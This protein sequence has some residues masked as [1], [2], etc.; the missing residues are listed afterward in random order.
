[1]FALWNKIFFQK[2]HSFY[3]RTI[4][5]VNLEKPTAFRV[6]VIR[7]RCPSC[8]KPFPLP[9]LLALPK[10]TRATPRSKDFALSLVVRTNGSLTTSGG[11]ASDFTHL[12]LPRSTLHDWKQAAAGNVPHRAIIRELKFSGVLCVDEFRPK[13]ERVFDLFAS[14]RKTGRI[15]YLDE[16]KDR[17]AVSGA[18]AEIF[19]KT[20]ASFGIYPKAII[21]DMG[22]GIWKGGTT[23]FPHALYQ[24]DYFHVMQSIH[25]KLRAEIR[26]VWWKLRQGG[27]QEDAAL[28]WDAQWTLLRNWESWKDRDEEL[29]L[30]VTHRFPSSMM[31]W[32]PAFKQELRDV[33]DHSRNK[34]EALQRRDAWI[35]RWRE[36]IKETKYL[37]K[38]V[39]LMTSHLFPSMITYLDHRWIQRTTNAETLI[40]TYRHMEKARYGFG[41]IKGRQNHLKLFQLKTYLA[42]KVG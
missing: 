22:G 42:Q 3:F 40:R 20:L 7:V 29:W 27:H 24:Y 21:A 26:S 13:R 14:D 2:K 30:Q 16:T 10:H 31:A 35:T 37:K 32:L 11:V 33:F 4:K 12:E 8:K 36:R 18:S 34:K 19:F 9:T 1:M 15:L 28:L 17:S 38:I 39:A 5:D 25:E 6:R 23:V 41:S